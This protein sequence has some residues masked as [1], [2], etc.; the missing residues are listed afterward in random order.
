MLRV[1]SLSTTAIG[2]LTFVSS[3]IALAGN[4]TGSGIGP[5]PDNNPGGIV[6]SFAV[7]GMTA[8]VTKVSLKLG[9]THTWVG[10]LNATLTSPAGVA[11]LVVFARTGAIRTAGTGFGDSS[12]LSGVYEFTD[13][14]SSDWYALAASLPD[15]GVLPPGQYR[16]TTAGVPTTSAPSVAGTNHGGCS[17]FLKGAFNGLLPADANGIW[18]LAV[19]DNGP[20]DTGTVTSAILTVS[21]EELFTNGFEPMVRGSCGHTLYD[22]TGTGRTSFALARAI[23]PD[24]QWLVQDN[25][26]T[27]T[28]ALSTFTLGT[29][30]TD[31]IVDGDFDGDGITDAAV[32]TP[33]PAGVAKFTIRRSTRPSQPYAIVFGKDGDDPAQCGDYDGDGISD[34][35]VF[36]D[37]DS[38]TNPAHTLIHPSSG[39]PDR[40]YVTGEDGNFAVGGLDYTGDGIADIAI[41]STFNVNDGHFRIYSGVDGDMVLEFLQGLDSDF[42]VPGNMLGSVNTDISTRRTVGTERQYTTRDMGTQLVQPIVVWGTTGDVSLSGDFDGD[43]YD[44]YAVWR[45]S[46][47]PGMSQ[48]IIRKSSDLGTLAYPMGQNMDFPPAGSRVH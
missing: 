42:I 23:G 39:A 15:G 4:F 43:G 7:S 33:G 34:V 19:S 8:P 35:A 3:S 14:A 10:D 2:F 5:I 28:G 40:N 25:D 31:Y 41:Q 22:Y 16:T 1:R 36:R 18:T 45:A 20:G 17:T 24:I 30:A 47:T 46:A 29:A 48:F 9:L 44:D 38:G 12:N 21:D 11:H 26:G 32:W 37:V 27:T 13:F 6:V